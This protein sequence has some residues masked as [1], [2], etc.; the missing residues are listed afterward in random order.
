[1]TPCT[2]L[3][4][5]ENYDLGSTSIP[6]NYIKVD[7][8]HAVRA[9]VSSRS[10]VL[11]LPEPLWIRFLP[12]TAV[13]ALAWRASGLVRRRPRRIV[14]YAIENNDVDTL[15]W[16]DRRMPSW[17]TNLMKGAIRFYINRSVDRIA[18]GSQG[19]AETYESL[20]LSR[21]IETRVIDEL[22][23]ASAPTT[24]GQANSAIFV[25]AFEKRKG[26]MQLM[27]AW[28]EVEQAVPNAVLTLVGVGALTTELEA[29]CSRH[30]DSRRLVGQL[31]HDEV[32]NTI[33]DHAV[34]VAPSVRSGRW[35]EQIG[36]PIVE[37]LSAGLT[38]VTTKDSGLSS[39][40]G[41]HGHRVL[42]TR[43][44]QQNLGSAI[45]DAFDNRIPVDVVQSE[46]PDVPARIEA[47]H[48]L[49]H[50]VEARNQK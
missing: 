12:T 26:I 44:L 41:D 10:S 29:W 24:A 47:D 14:S 19:A 28:P 3:Y 9:L 22:P 18:F 21:S 40:L 23:S 46:L 4:F 20:H 25:G 48:W 6:S 16:G 32:R 36:L 39:W 11:E 17:L 8:V 42:E 7:L 35:R 13:L 45:V 50:D 49:H 5:D 1:M 38:I 15:L 34:L 30:P 43:Y 2:V 31:Q 33:S 37:G 27:S